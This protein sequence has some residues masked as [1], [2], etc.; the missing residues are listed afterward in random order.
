MSHKKA[1][2]VTCFVAF[3]WSL[4]GFFVKAIQ[5]PSLA[6]NS[7]KSIITAICLLP[8]MSRLSVK[9]VSKP[10]IMGAVCYALFLY[11]FTYST[12]MTTSA[13]AIVMQYTSPVYVAMF[14]RYLLHEPVYKSDIIAIVLVFIGMFLFFA[15]GFDTSRFWG[16]AVSVFN[17][18]TFA[19]MAI[20]FRMQKSQHPI[21]SVFL[22]N[23]LVV[24]IGLPTLLACSVPDTL[25]IACIFF[26][27][28]QAAV[29]FL[30]YTEASKSLTGLEI[31]LLPILDPLLTPVWVYLFMGETITL[32]AA[33]GALIILAAVT[34]RMLIPQKTAA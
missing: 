24:F 19:G 23:L 18:I 4:A 29:S 10:V 34:A 31:V 21:V 16:N 26:Y 3:L 25:S 27:G 7:A 30:L 9:T 13:V 20:A 33:I 6:M 8:V 5:M 32:T 14:S 17:G 1:V 15:D 11:S 12:K 2:A 22:E 28:I